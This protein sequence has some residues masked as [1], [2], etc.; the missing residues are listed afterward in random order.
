MAAFDFM[1]LLSPL[2]GAT[3]KNTTKSLRSMASPFTK[4]KRLIANGSG[5]K[6]RHSKGNIK[7]LGT[8]GAIA[9]S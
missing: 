2:H 3:A 7:A 6:H 9:R 5:R 8:D 4:A 1:K